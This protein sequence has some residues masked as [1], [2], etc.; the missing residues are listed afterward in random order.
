[1]KIAILTSE[2]ITENNWHGG[3]ANYLY[4]IA[5]GLSDKGHDV[6]VFVYSDKH[7][8][9]ENEGVKIYRIFF[10]EK[11]L[12]AFNILTLRLMP[13]FAQMIYIAY[14]FR[15]YFLKIIK[16][17]KFD[18]IHSSSCQTPALF[19]DPKRIG[20]PIVTRLSSVMKLCQV[21]YKR[22]NKFDMFLINQVEKRLIKKSNKVFA[23]SK[24]VQKKVKEE[25]NV[26]IDVLESP[27]YFQ[28]A[29][30]LD[31]E[32]YDKYLKGKKYILFYGTLGRLKGSEHIADIIYDFLNKYTDFYFVIVGKMEIL[33]KRT[34]PIEPILKNAKEHKNRVIYTNSLHHQQLF[35]IIDNSKAVFLPSMIDNLPNTCIESMSLGKIVI[36]TYDGG[37]DQLIEDGKN[38]YLINYGDKKRLMKIFDII[39]SSENSKLDNIGQVAKET[40]QKRLN[41]EQKIIELENYYKQAIS[42]CK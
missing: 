11:Y 22:K 13:G 3:L 38:G 36:G 29:K 28:E 35:P 32:V 33:R 18:I 4:R 31:H 37:F 30:E 14:K 26:L 40:V 16:T 24:L 34:L 2:Y 41:F 9:I 19:L 12:W 10:N 42:Q 25:F 8:V 27:E 21:A 20:I 6:T 17:E 39:C 1:M 5:R 15:K 7:E 23:P